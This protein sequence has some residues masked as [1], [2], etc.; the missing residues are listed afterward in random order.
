MAVDRSISI[1]IVDD[2]SSLSRIIRSLL[3]RSGFKDIEQ[4]S[5]GAA[6]LERLK[7]KPFS[8]IICDWHMA[9]MTGF[10]LLSQVRKD[11][12]LDDVRF[13][14]ITADANAQIP[15]VARAMGADGFLMKPF[16]DE[17]LDDAIEQA[18]WTKRY[19]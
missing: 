15:A 13:L 17:A 7:L 12:T 1:L 2:F 10:E 18:F 14:I 11:R 4:V 3:E 16:T 8:V 5:N 9:P 19:R 6:A